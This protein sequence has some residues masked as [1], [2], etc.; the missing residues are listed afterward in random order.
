MPATH[1]LLAV[2]AIVLTAS[3]SSNG[4]GLT[5]PDAVAGVVGATASGLFNIRPLSIFTGHCNASIAR[6]A[7]IWKPIPGVVDIFFPKVKPPRCANP[8]ACSLINSSLHANVILQPG[9]SLRL[10]FDLDFSSAAGER[11][12]Q[13][14]KK[15]LPSTTDSPRAATTVPTTTTASTAT[16]IATDEMATPDAISSKESVVLKRY[17]R[18][19]VGGQTNAAVTG[20][21]QLPI[22]KSN[23]VA[24]RIR[25]MA[26]ADNQ[27]KKMS[28]NGSSSSTAIPTVSNIVTLYKV[29]GEAFESCDIANSQRIGQV[30]S[31]D[32]ESHTGVITLP[33]GLLSIADNFFLGRSVRWGGECL[34]M[35]VS[36]KTANCGDRDQCTNNG[37]CHAT[38]STASFQCSCC[39]SANV[40]EFCGP[41]NLCAYNPCQNEGVCIRVQQNKD[42]LFRCLCLPGYEGKFCEEQFNACDSMVCHNGGSCLIAHDGRAHCSCPSGFVGLHCEEELT[43]CDSSPCVHGICVDQTHG[44]RCFCQP[45]FGGPECNFEYNECESNP[46]ANGGTCLDRVGEFQCICPSGYAGSR[47]ETQVNLCEPNPCG[48]NQ[49]CIDH[50]TNISCECIPGLDPALCA[51]MNSACHP[52]PCLRGGTCWVSSGSFFCACKPGLTGDRCQDLVTIGNKAEH[53]EVIRGSV[54]HYGLSSSELELK[55]PLPLHLDHTHSVYV[56]V[57]TLISVVIVVVIAV[58]ACYCRTHETSKWSPSA[59]LPFLCRDYRNSSSPIKE[60][61][62]MDV[63]LAVAMESETFQQRKFESLHPT[64]C[65]VYWSEARRDAAVLD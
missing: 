50:G 9:D 34:K 38:S 16:P 18:Q 19:A 21:T 33:P 61:Q 12:D 42:D 51:E 45:G 47:C 63:P 53:H 48:L 2:L 44:Y 5:T 17:P 65:Q 64:Q 57:G 25:L 1:L 8:S 55:T 40:N 24:E 49:K 43:G 46:C 58:T 54:G 11:D 6:G 56:A 31:Q 7:T 59:R 30:K 32:P 36:V 20:P 3:A 52:N 29:N 23:V 28:V 26:Q 62:G 60:D 39:E 35:K 4:G 41:S 13:P 27:G 15:M 14:A 22:Q 10:T 37:V